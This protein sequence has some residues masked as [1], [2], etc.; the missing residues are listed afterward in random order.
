MKVLVSGAGGFL[1]QAVVYR[2]LERG[3]GVRAIIR[4]SSPRPTWPDTVEVF[5]ADLRVGNDQVSAFDGVDAV[6][7]LA[8]ATSGDEDAQFTSTVIGTERFLEAMAKSSVKRLIHVS[9][10]VVYDWSKAKSCMDEVSSLENAPY[11]MGGYTIA[12]IWQ[13]RVVVRFADKHSLNVTI[14]RPGFIWGAGHAQ[15]SAMGRRLG[16]LYLLFGPFTRLP[17]SH[18]N[19]CA[20][21][22][23]TAVENPAASG[24]IFNV[25]DS[26]DIRVWR[27][28][29]EY[30][31]RTG[32]RG[33]LLPV[34]YR[35]GLGIAR[36]AAFTSRR[37]FGSKGK[38]PSL[39]T[40]RRFE[41]QFKPI[42]FS[43]RKVKSK[44]DWTPRLGFDEC[45]DASFDD[46]E[47]RAKAPLQDV[48]P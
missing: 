41:S 8:A 1:G 4:P 11:S 35:L 33:V 15:I 19:N 30:V 25:V 43:N 27:Y 32:Q 14:V 48:R 39:L 29:R 42:R 12:K 45:L 3:H 34:P 9:S 31:R 2:L 17:L 5:R 10:L 23:V 40:P 7:H 6:L 18:V 26:D 47:S 44:L 36:L 13:E 46:M 38:L 28:A 22:L 37:L 16:R 20:D 24:E 21:C